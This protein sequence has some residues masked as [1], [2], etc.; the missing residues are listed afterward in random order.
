M[1]TLQIYSAIINGALDTV[2]KFQSMLYIL[3]RDIKLEFQY[4]STIKM[5]GVSLKISSE[6]R[7]LILYCAIKN[8]Q[9]I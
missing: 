8:F 9:R 7:N 2:P 5:C 1:I 3:Y 4:H 6:M